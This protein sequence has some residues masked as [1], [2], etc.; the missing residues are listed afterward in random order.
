ML[1]VNVSLPC[2]SR[3]CLPLPFLYSAAGGDSHLCGNWLSS[4]KAGGNADW[5]VEPCC[6]LC[7]RHVDHGIFVKWRCLFHNFELTFVVGSEVPTL[8]Q[9]L[10]FLWSVD[11]FG[12]NTHWF[13]LFGLRFYV[14]SAPSVTVCI[15]L[16]EV[17]AATFHQNDHFFKNNT[18]NFRVSSGEGGPLATTKWSCARHCSFCT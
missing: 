16:L 7:A 1:H 5:A 3:F 14:F 18:Y 4:L 17:I 15:H 8:K 6:S 2:L 9:E 11:L 12:E 13:L 10:H